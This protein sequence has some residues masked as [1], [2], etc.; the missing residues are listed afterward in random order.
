MDALGTSLLRSGSLVLL[1][2]VLGL[3]QPLPAQV[4]GN[5]SSQAVGSYFVAYRTP[6]QLS[7]SGPEVFHGIADQTLELLKSKHVVLVSDPERPSFQTAELFSLESLLKLA[8]EAGASHLL[9]LTVDRPA[10]KWVKITLQCFDFSGKLLWEADRK[11][12]V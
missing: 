5:S 3:S 12:V 10:A 1:A 11:S 8:R 7:R 6:A 2:G 4:A 9:Y